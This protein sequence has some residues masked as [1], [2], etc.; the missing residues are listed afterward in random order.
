MKSLLLISS[1]FQRKQL[2]V[3]VLLLQAVCYAQVDF[4]DSNLPIVIINTPVDP[5]TGLPAEIPDDPKILADMKIIFRPDGSR[6]FVT[7]Q[8]NEDYLDYNGK[9]KIELR[10]SSSQM[11]EKK[12]YGW[13]TYEDDGETKVNVSI[14]GMPKENDWILNGLAFDASLIRDYLNYNL[15]RQMGQYATRTQ[16]CEV[17]LN[18]DYRGLYILQEK[19]KD[20]SNR[21]NI[22]EITEDDNEGVN[23]TGGYI[24]KSDKTTGDDPIAWQMESYAGL[25][26]FI[27]ELPKP[28][29]V[30]E[31]QNDYI[32]SQFTSLETATGNDDDDIVTGYP[33]IIDVPTFIDYMLINELSSNVDV[34]QI[35]T[36]FHKDR[37]GK[38]RAGPVWDF[39]LSLGLDVF[40]E[41]SKTDVWQFSNGD[42]EGA[43]FW[44]DL[45]NNETYKCYFS[46]RW[47]QL[48]ATGQP[49]NYD[50]ITEFIDDTVELI[51][52]AGARDKER[53]RTPEDFETEI[54]LIKTFISDRTAWITDNIGPFT[55]CDNQ[56]VPSLVISKINYNPGESDEFPESNDQ[57][58]I[59]ITNTGTDTVDLTGIYLSELG[60]SY[61]FPADAE[62]EGGEKIYLVSNTEVF[63]ERYDMEAFGQFVRNMPNSTQKL[64]LSD[65]FGNRIDIVEY[66]DDAP[67]P[68][69]D[70]N[71]SY[72]KLIDNTSDNNLASSW[73]ATDVGL[74][75]ESFEAD[76]TIQMYPNPVND[77][78]I[79]R[80]DNMIKNIE[81]Y[82]ISG[83]MLLSTDQSATSL[84]IDFSSYASGMYFVE[85]HG[86]NGSKTQKIFKR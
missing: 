64:V 41:R 6:N 60:I 66:F 56:E 55:G 19:I 21:V 27:H 53:W 74:S 28:D 2:L 22:E 15:T 83:K 12:Q 75:R 1:V 76:I 71:G 20:D 50:S 30:T 16:Y 36:F 82:D 24:T 79:V 25:T 61:Q 68:D 65:A 39:N 49:L 11:L 46:K 13:T 23:L 35:S 52:E 86:E 34:Y 3:I 42:N 63:E 4:T 80:S 38:L 81:V 54:D 44:T 29:E 72:L 62:I 84:S 48:I 58:F 77:Q 47:N 69:A 37:G 8:E 43:K 57:E 40:G 73:I 7:D 70:G 5:D 18:G 14:L 26:D 67:W 45:F 85:V 51:S 78:L 32:H 31:E 59:E 10:G 9:I 17:I 33:S